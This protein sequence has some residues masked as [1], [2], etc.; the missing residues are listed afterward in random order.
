MIIPFTS[1][2]SCCPCTS[3]SQRF[4]LPVAPRANHKITLAHPVNPKDAI[5]PHEGLARLNTLFEQGIKISEIEIN[6]P[7]D[8]LA[9][10][11][12]TL[13]SLSMLRKLYPNIPVSLTT[14]GLGGEQ[15]IPQLA[16][17][18]LSRLILQV[19]TLNRTTAQKIYTWIRPATKNIRLPQA[20]ELL[21]AEQP[22][23]MS[24]CKD[25]GLP[26]TVRTTVYPGFNDQE[27]PD[28]A[29]RIAELGA[30]E[31]VLAPFS[32]TDM[33]SEEKNKEQDIEKLLTAL[34]KSCAG[35]LPTSIVEK[36]DIA[37]KPSSQASSSGA[38][39]LLPSPT[40]ERPNVAVVSS[41]GMD[42][43]LHLGQAIQIL[44]Y[45]PRKNDGLASLIETRI[46]PEAGSGADRWKTLAQTLND[47]F[48]LLASNAGDKPRK[49][50]A[51]SGITVLLSDDNV[52]GTVDV[53]YGGGKKGKKG[54]NKR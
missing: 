19:D 11:Q 31:L 25:I 40:K 30:E 35:Y 32:P 33:K 22:V 15:L 6:G 13:D 4:L 39:G 28:I 26:L 14:L 27:I 45:G 41:N 44:I 48:V 18:G 38:G 1:K 52:E 43:D 17:S 3:T 51:A 8:P 7:G 49:V 9:L 36:C 53:L 47:C 24:I 29:K 2:S 34:Q 46:A 23:S 54:K 16:L 50:L 42:I 37:L 10:I 12:P 20:V 5:L 21:L